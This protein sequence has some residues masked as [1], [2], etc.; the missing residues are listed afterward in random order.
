MD[1]K[2]K[3]ENWRSDGN[4]QLEIRYDE[5]YE[6]SEEYYVDIILSYMSKKMQDKDMDF[7]QLFLFQL[8]EL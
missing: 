1:L 7:I 2:I 5:R 4:T 3:K 6:G 8:S